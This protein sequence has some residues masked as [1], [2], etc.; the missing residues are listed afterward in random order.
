MGSDVKLTFGVDGVGAGGESYE[1]IKKD[2]ESIITNIGTVKFKLAVD[3]KALSEIKGQIQDLVKFTGNV[4]KASAILGGEEELPIQHGTSEYYKV[5]KLVNDELTRVEM[6]QYKFREATNSSDA[7]I[8]EAYSNLEKYQY[9]LLE[10][11]ERLD[12]NKLKM[13]DFSLEFTKQ[14]GLFADTSEV[15]KSSSEKI[16]GTDVIKTGTVEYTKALTQI[17]NAIK[18]VQDRQAQWEAS[19]SGTK[20]ML[21]ANISEYSATADIL[22][23]YKTEVESGTV[24]TKEF[25]EVMSFVKSELAKTGQ[26]SAELI[27]VEKFKVDVVSAQTQ[28]E[29]LRQSL[30]NTKREAERFK[31]GGDTFVKEAHIARIN[32]L[33]EAVENLASKLEHEPISKTAFSEEFRSLSLDITKAKND[34]NNFLN[35][36]TIVS[37]STE[38]YDAMRQIQSELS[39]VEL[40]QLKFREATS[41]GDENIKQAYAS[42]DVYRQSL[43]DLDDG[44]STGEM[45]MADFSQE[46]AKQRYMIS[47]SA[48]VLQ[49][50]S[51]DIFGT[52]AIEAGTVE[53]TQ[54]L[55]QISTMLKSVGDMQT[56]WST[57]VAG[58]NGSLDKSIATLE[59]S[60]ESISAFEN[61]VRSGEVSAKEFTATMSAF[62]SEIAKVSEEASGIIN[63]EKLNVFAGND[64]IKTD[65]VDY[66]NALSQVASMLKKVQD[67]QTSW[68]T[69]LAGTKG[70]LDSNISELSASASLIQEFS[71][72]MQTGEV[73]TREFAETM[74]FFKSEIAQADAAASNIINI[75]KLN[76]FGGNEKIKADTVEYTNALASVASMLKSVQDMQAGWSSSLAGTRGMLEDSLVELAV[77]EESLK[78]FDQRLRDGNV[79]AKEF[80]DTMSSFKNALA[81][82]SVNASQIINTEKMKADV[83]GAQ[84]QLE[85]LSQSLIVVRRNAE[86]FRTDDNT[87]ITDAHI[88]RID[89]LRE[90]INELS[91]RLNSGSLTGTAFGEEFKSL[92][93]EVNKTKNTI[94]NF[95][96]DSP[97]YADVDNAVTSIVTLKDSLETAASKARLFDGGAASGTGGFV[98]NIESV[99]KSLDELRTKVENGMERDNYDVEM[100][101]IKR[102][103]T[104]AKSALDAF[105][106]GQKEAE[107]GIIVSGTQQYNKALSQT[108]DLMGKLATAQMKYAKYQASTNGD[109]KASYGALSGY[110][111]EV[112]SLRKQLETGKLSQA[113]FTNEIERLSQAAL[114][115]INQL[116]QY[117][118]S[119]ATLSQQINNVTTR[120]GGMFTGYMLLRRGMSTIREMINE[121][122]ELDDAMT[123]MRI[124]TKATGDQM[125]EFG[126]DISAA[127]Q[128]VAA[129]ITDL[130]DA[131]TTFARLGYDINSSSKLAEFT[132][133]LQQVGDISADSA[134]DAITSIMK[135]FPKDADVK[136]I[137][138]VMDKLVKTGNNFPISVSQIA[139]GMTNASS[140]LAAAGNSFD[141]SVALLTAANVTIQD[142]SRSSTGLRTIAA[143]IRNTKT[144]LDALGET[145]NF[146]K[147]DQLVQA[148]TRYN[149]KLTDVT[150]QYRSTYDILQDISKIWDQLNSMEQ[151]ALAQQLAGTRQQA[152]FYSII[153]QFKEAEDAVTAMENAGGT[154]KESYDFYLDSISAHV[155]TFKNAWVDLSSTIA[156]KGTVTKIVDTGTAIVNVANKLAKINLLL[157]TIIT[158]IV[159]IRTTMQLIKKEAAFTSISKSIAALS[160]ESLKAAASQQILAESTFNLS[161]AQKEALATTITQKL[162]TSGMAK[163]D[164]SATL[165]KMGLVTATEA[166]IVANNG[167]LASVRSLMATNPVG[168][169]MLIA[170]FI[171][172]IVDKIQDLIEKNEDAE[173]SWGKLQEEIK[174]TKEE[175]SSA[176]ESYRDM[177]D[178]VDEIV[179]RLKELAIG[180]DALGN[181]VALSSDD[182]NEFID[183]QNK[184]GDLFPDI[185]KCADENGNKIIKLRDVTSEY[186]NVLEEQIELQRKA[187]LSDVNAKM[188]KAFSDELKF[189]ASEN[190]EIE[191]MQ[192]R[193]DALK[194]I[195]DGF[196]NDGII[197]TS[198]IVTADETDFLNETLASLGITEDDIEEVTATTLDIFTNSLRSSK[199]MNGID[200]TLASL[201]DPIRE[202]IGKLMGKAMD[203]IAEY[204]SVYFQASDVYDKIPKEIRAL[205]LSAIGELDFRSAGITTTEA[206][207]SYV[208]DNFIKP[209]SDMTPATQG[210][211]QNM[212]SVSGAFSA[213]KASAEDYINALDNVK[214]MLAADGFKDNLTDIILGSLDDNGIKSKFD[215][216]MS[217]ITGSEQEVRSFINTCSESDIEIVFNVVEQSNGI[218]LDDVKEKLL[219][220]KSIVEE[221]S[222]NDALDLSGVFG[223]IDNV[224]NDISSITNEMQ[225]LQK[226]TSLTAKEMLALAKKYPQLLKQA[227]LFTD[228]SIAGQ[229]KLLD[230][231]MECSKKEFNTVLD[232]KIKELEMVKS[233]LEAQKKIEQEKIKYMTAIHEQLIK[234]EISDRGAY[235]KAVEELSKLELKQYA[236]YEGGKITVAS[237]TLN[238]IEQDT[239]DFVNTVRDSAYV[240]NAENLANTYKAGA[241]DVIATTGQM[242]KQIMQMAVNNETS[243]NDAVWFAKATADGWSPAEA[244]NALYGNNLV[245]NLRQAV[246]SRGGYTID[247]ALQQLDGAIADANRF[248]DN[249]DTAILEAT[250]SINNLEALKNMDFSLEVT[251]SNTSSSSSSSEDKEQQERDRQ[252]EELRRKIRDVLNQLLRDLKSFYDAQKQMLKDQLEDEKYLKEQA[253]KRKTVN[254]LENLIAQLG[255]DDSAWAKKRRIALGKELQD[256][257]DK[258]DEFEQNRAVSEAEKMYDEEYA[259]QAA[260][261][262]ELLADNNVTVEEINDKL[263]GI[264]NTLKGGSAPSLG[265]PYASGTRSATA[266]LHMIDERGS[267]TIF[268]SSNGNRYRM[269]S[270]G[271]KVLNAGASDFLYRFA[272]SYGKSL[273]GGAGTV[274]SGIA[275]S[276]GSAITMGNIIINGDAS[277]RTVSEIRR[278]QREQMRELLTAF[279][280]MK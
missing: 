223:D 208:D 159:A 238:V 214:R 194:A 9:A 107:S 51:K 199:F 235:L 34:L 131:T 22:K 143:R 108:D 275:R 274:P 69:S 132:G 188:D 40:A 126:D 216:I 205:F 190:P 251:D 31:D 160:P 102:S 58:T 157:P 30:I 158:S 88:Q 279:G 133:M 86:K 266:G 241:G 82:T 172:T 169:I 94:D 117:S 246:S 184:L 56:S 227:N 21:R 276:G 138:L 121:A 154:L 140:A 253:E 80:T 178:A 76:A 167:L 230:T 151:A 64:K 259:K 42:L 196:K 173:N 125:V 171:P 8:R 272:S 7:N 260:I 10:M 192:R 215:A 27:N 141:K 225:K 57:S 87:F 156:D 85:N 47:A 17:S 53:Y 11:E 237:K 106:R 81:Q 112:A 54:A 200:D 32:E 72:K 119:T 207:R 46:L 79:T 135:A 273:M 109:I 60:A 211:I 128:R 249:I 122:I 226:G 233:N 231:V 13:S 101:K 268:Q 62:R 136:N 166:E 137:E 193:L 4:N 176:L 239:V 197:D 55:T 145:D 240:P 261:I 221:I 29:G 277:E 236:K 186:N 224:A 24:T 152:V 61:R 33:S 41:S 146:A 90:K 97:I 20:D 267:E 150:G 162:E 180:V 127:A 189:K 185:V 89:E 148:L 115:A 50:N 165:A 77:E 163:E 234:G 68:S 213:G 202:R 280:R 59:S 264:Y 43:K 201:E 149:V 114:P 12:G 209:I 258:L 218:S 147:Y 103:A 67:M 177:R 99:M 278:A 84:N 206:M 228:G 23:D 14:R 73:T 229:K 174:Q 144:E 70:M 271:E 175:I 26:S 250:N 105:Y 248:L 142:A 252:Q 198:N 1:Q 63:A 38:Y 104:E 18:S 203:D 242:F 247:G 183:I 269:F 45:K 91:T 256:A 100:Q 219:D 15:L 257:K 204:A 93:L 212:V 71:Q 245:Y 161:R 113:D 48:A 220:I 210:A 134:Q 120:I 49:Q 5:L 25:A 98:A 179:P 75:E 164:I 265:A 92:S 78:E 95:L 270:G 255:L 129:P 263:Q 168:W 36:G 19:A 222:V 182:Y 52:E 116:E 262:N 254:D 66:T 74:S 139:T 110:A 123:Q 124:V 170:S 2:L 195:R 35:D 3:D 16:F 191:R 232:T 44:L 118:T 187:Y 111:A 153:E 28:L 6:T 37:G 217:G 243:I 181:N 39:K 130:V 155:N 96:K 244:W 83:T 65:T